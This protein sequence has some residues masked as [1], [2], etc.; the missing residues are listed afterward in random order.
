MSRRT[1]PSR[2]SFGE[3]CLFGEELF[4]GDSDA[5]SISSISVAGSSKR[6]RSPTEDVG[7]EVKKRGRGRPPTT[8]EYVGLAVAKA[9]L[10]AA[11]R[12][13]FET[14]EAT[15]LLRI[16][17]TGTR[18][19]LTPA[20]VKARMTE[21]R[22]Q[23]F[24][25][26]MAN[27]FEHLDAVERV[28]TTSKNLKG[29]Y[30]KILRDETSEIK[31]AASAII[32][33]NAEQE[34]EETIILRR[35]VENLRKELQKMKEELRRQQQQ[36]REDSRKDMDGA[37]ATTDSPPPKSPPKRQQRTA[38]QQA[39]GRLAESSD[40]EGEPLS[41]QGKRTMSPSPPG[42]QELDRS[43]DFGPFTDRTV[44]R[45]SPSWEQKFG[46]LE[47]R[48][49]RRVGDLLEARPKP[50]PTSSSFSPSPAGGPTLPVCEGLGG[51]P[52][53]CPSAGGVEEGVESED[54]ASC[55]GGC[56][57]LGEEGG[58]L[59]ET[60]S[61]GEGTCSPCGA[62]EGTTGETGPQ[63]EEEEI[64]VAGPTKDPNL[65]RGGG[66]LRRERR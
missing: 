17:P 4:G 13:L 18:P 30:V 34:S 12:E 5:E 62:V 65:G 35:E 6:P 51:R 8:G 44:A 37:V 1:S 15:E 54:V 39:G 25:E 24:A 33:R 43:K 55:K 52:T 47:D 42:E 32:E 64:R 41:P 46:R 38:A 19:R 9:R 7:E 59:R 66:P 40:D 2:S 20:Q 48:I 31:L 11:E 50:G 53:F 23:P 3:E 26:L 56:Y 36:Q 57:I 49:L 21:L 61:Y 45:P 27:V 22:A 16:A 10:A 63:E 58:N 28:A 60:A 29:P 14:R